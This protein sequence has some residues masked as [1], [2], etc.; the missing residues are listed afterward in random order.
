M[1]RILKT[2]GR[3]YPRAWRERYGEEFDAILED[4]KPCLLDIADVLLGAF[5]MRVSMRHLV[6][7]VLPC[8]LAGAAI[9]WGIAARTPARYSSDTVVKFTSYRLTP[10]C[11]NPDHLPATLRPSKDIC[12]EGGAA[13]DKLMQAWIQPALD[14][15]FLI[16]VIKTKRLY[17]EQ[18]QSHVPIEQLVDTMRA[19]INLRPI[20]SAENGASTQAYRIEFQYSEPRLAQDVVA[21]LASRSMDAF[22]KSSLAQIKAQGVSGPR[23]YARTIAIVRT[24]SFST[25]PLGVS[26]VHQVELGFLAGSLAGLLLTLS[27]GSKSAGESRKLRS[28]S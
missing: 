2:L 13:I 24:P 10:V 11:S 25:T 9:A 16:S 21:L 6:Q 4:R 27:L 19:H 26:R 22:I 28:E 3:L 1:K 7:I 18:Q 8:G 23:Q 20:G 14:R 12:G 15:D 17:W 5:R